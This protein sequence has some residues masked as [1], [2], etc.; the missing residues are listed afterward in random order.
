[1][2]S[3]TL[4]SHFKRGRHH[5][6]IVF[7]EAGKGEPIPPPP[8][9]SPPSLSSLSPSPSYGSKS[10]PSSMASSA[11]KSIAL[12]TMCEHNTRVVGLD[13][14]RIFETLSTCLGNNL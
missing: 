12:G 10:M 2:T 9:L 1:M 5:P 13:S 8:L 11:N 14:W 7:A 3:G 4:L 6:P